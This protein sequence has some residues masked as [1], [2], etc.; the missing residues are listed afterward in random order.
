MSHNLDRGRW[1]ASRDLLP[2]H[3]ADSPRASGRPSTVLAASAR[4]PDELRC[5]NPDCTAVLDVTA[6]PVEYEAILQR[7][8]FTPAG[9]GKPGTVASKPSE[10]PLVP[11][12]DFRAAE[13]QGDNVTFAL[14]VA[15]ACEAATDVQLPYCDAC[16]ESTLKARSRA[17]HDASDDRDAVVHFRDMVESRLQLSLGA[18]GNAGHSSEP[19]EAG[20]AAPAVRSALES[21]LSTLAAEEASLLAEVEAL[22]VEAAAAQATRVLLDTRAAALAELES[23]WWDEFRCTSRAVQ[24]SRTR[25]LS[26]RVR[27][28]R[29]RDLLARLRHLNVLSDAFFIWHRGPLVTING[30]RLG[31]LPGLGIDW[32]EINSALGQAAMLTAVVA[33]RIGFQVRLCATARLRAAAFRVS[34]GMHTWAA[35]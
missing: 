26:L 31:R 28:L 2:V 18:I 25:M 4:N 10:P 6:I 19:S 35:A 16:M 15:L 32:P 1:A 14:L 13:K 17:F 29:Y 12:E 5:Q 9:G 24:A 33:T 21:A 20:S 8:L 22:R 11:L 30:C 3:A 27:N 23:R 34:A 7:L